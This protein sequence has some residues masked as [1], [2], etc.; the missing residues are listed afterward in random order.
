MDSHHR[1]D[2]DWVVTLIGMHQQLERKAYKLLISA[3]LPS[4]T[5][6][7]DPEGRA[8]R[9]GSSNSPAFIPMKQSI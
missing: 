4:Y 1:F 9:H 5:P 8:V 2:K 6:L 3:Y 7:N